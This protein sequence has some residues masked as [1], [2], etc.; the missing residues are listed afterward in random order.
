MASESGHLT[1]VGPS[2]SLSSDG[3]PFQAFDDGA[4]V[5]L[6]SGLRKVYLERRTRSIEWRKRQLEGIVKLVE[7][8]EDEIAEVLMKDLARPKIQSLS[9]DIV[10]SI[11]SAKRA[12]KNLESWMKP[13]KVATDLLN[14]PG[15]SLIY[16]E[17]LGVVLIIAPWNL[18][19]ELLL[20]PL[21]GAV[22]AGN[23]AVL[24]PSELSPHSS[25]LLARLV[26]KYLDTSA[27]KVVEGAV[28]ETTALLNQRWDLIFFTGSTAVGR[29][30]MA[31]ASKHL[32]PV[33][34]ELGGKNPVY[35][36]DSVDLK[37]AVK[38]IVFGM[39]LNAGQA[40][41]SP[42]YILIPASFKDIFIDEVR[43]HLKEAYGEDPKKSSDL[44]RIISERHVARIRGL[45][46][47]PDVADKIILG[48]D[49]D[50][51]N[52][53]V[54]PTVL[55]DVPWNTPLME[56]EN[57]GPLLAVQSVRDL[58][59]AI[60]IINGRPKALAVYV[61]SKK[62]EV[63]ARIV[64]ETSSGA[65]LA[66]DT[67]VHYTNA[68]L[69]YGGVGESGMGTCHGKYSFDAFS[70]QKTVM[71]KSFFGDLDARYPPSTPLKESL[72]RH[73]L[74]LDLFGALLVLLGL[75]K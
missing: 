31:A 16:P 33:V 43:K 68:N 67:V 47:H 74:L 28:S 13:K 29:I 1:K 30:V 3:L 56:E 65:V 20:Q 61:F 10:Q 9:L 53:F 5:E 19:F 60:E 2:E 18:P 36:D 26:P 52:L 11:G 51:A 38:R 55:V 7:E 4:A 8:N 24:K 62:K 73:I 39:C 34:L 58:D 69:P 21:I 54:A 15:K 72:M 12:I 44:S 14:M 71:E 25:T 57:F 27:I 63:V 23:A 48:G 41:L 50:E 22:A 6:V 32:T 70:H 45:L 17:P 59:E 46:T 42:D 40:C 37:V 66:N 35:I 49:V 64:D 75:K